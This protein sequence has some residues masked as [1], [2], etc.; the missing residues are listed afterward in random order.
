MKAY[1][2]FACMHATKLAFEGGGK[3]FF[4]SFPSA[5]FTLFHPGKVLVP[6]L[7]GSR[8]TFDELQLPA[9]KLN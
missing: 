9:N 6:F 4:F 8:M 7:C 2:A 3:S 1:P 5:L